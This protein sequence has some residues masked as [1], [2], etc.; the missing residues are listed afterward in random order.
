VGARANTDLASAMPCAAGPAPMWQLVPCDNNLGLRAVI[1]VPGAGRR[2]G[3]VRAFRRRRFWASNPLPRTAKMEIRAIMPS[4]LL[5]RGWAMVFD[6][7]GGGSF[8]LGPR[9]TRVIRPRLIGGQNFTAADLL[10]AG[11]VAIVIA[12]M[13]DGLAVGGLTFTLDPKMC[14]LPREE[15][16]EEAE[17]R[18]E[19][20]K[21]KEQEEEEEEE[22][23]RVVHVERRGERAEG[24]RER[25]RPRRIRLEVDL[26]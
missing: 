21:E 26:D 16:E 23:E 5:A 12:V 4:F 14:A 11:D 15:L 22:H 25:D 19:A 10:A 18:A 2:R 13:A 1:P 3:L 7:P 6:N 8:S 9:N 17:E 24:E 20:E